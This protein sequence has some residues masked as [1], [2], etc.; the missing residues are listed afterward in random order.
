MS[1]AVTVV[2]PFFAAEE[3]LEGRIFLR[4]KAK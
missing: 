4:L 2:L 1:L 3:I